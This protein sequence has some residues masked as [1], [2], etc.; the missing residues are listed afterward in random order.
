M[1]NMKEINLSEI[2]SALL[3]KAWL[4]V[5]CAVVVGVLAF[6]YTTYFVT[7]MYHSSIKVYVDNKVSSENTVSSVN[8]SD[9]SASQRLV[10]TYI[11]I[12]KSEVVLTPVAEKIGDGIAPAGILAAMTAHAVGETE[13]FEVTIS[14]ENRYKAAEIANAIA[15]VAPA[16]IAE[17]RE[18]SSTKILE[19]AKPAE[20]QYSPNK[21][22]NTALGMLGGALI[23]V[24][25]IVLQTLLDVRIKGEEDLASISGAPVL[26]LIPDLAMDGK[27]GYGYSG[28]KYGTYT[29]KT[30][31]PASGEAEA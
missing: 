3:K 15:D 23:A 9:L 11:G 17:I 24:V 19:R 8:T 27:E 18:G 26:G 12:L 28:Y 29:A 16:I 5:I 2:F 22:K 13:I 4:I 14:H 7:P 25:V 20:N 10:D 21:T 31:E 6:V 30:R 1:D